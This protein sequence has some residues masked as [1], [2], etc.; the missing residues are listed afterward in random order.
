MVGVVKTGPSCVCKHDQIPY[1][2]VWLQCKRNASLSITPLWVPLQPWT[3]GHLLPC[4]PAVPCLF[5]S[6]CSIPTHH[7]RTVLFTC[8]WRL[9]L[10]VENTTPTLSSMFCSD[11]LWPGLSSLLPLPSGHRACLAATIRSS[12]A[13][14][15]TI[16]L[17]ATNLIANARIMGMSLSLSL[18]LSFS[19]RVWHYIFSKVTVPTKLVAAWPAKG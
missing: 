19:A 2:N 11:T 13:S 12:G 8:F 18:S 7:R 10:P 14:Q 3:E 4:F 15:S 1:R 6:F 9:I 5:S 17:V 16:K